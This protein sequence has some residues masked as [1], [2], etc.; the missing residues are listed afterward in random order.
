MVCYNSLAEMSEIIPLKWVEK[1]SFMSPDGVTHV[2]I[3]KTFFPLTL[4][5]AL[6]IGLLWSW[7]IAMFVIIGWGF[8]GFGIDPDLDLS[9]FNRSEAL[10]SKLIITIPLI[11]WS[12]FYARIFQKWGG[13]RSIWTH[14]FIISTFIRLMFFGLPFLWW[15]RQHWID[16]LTRE[17]FG[18]YIGMSI[19]DNL[20][21]IAD[22]ITGEMNFFSRIGGKNIFLKRIMKIWFDYP[23]TKKNDY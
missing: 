1:G 22:M 4:I 8:H 17:F 16:D 12:T 23:P 15:F 6:G 18:M 9:G 2:K 11:G 14:G 21:I 10:W 5:V 7:Y 3:W 19:S 13:H 20:H